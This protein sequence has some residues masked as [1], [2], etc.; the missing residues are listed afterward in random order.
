VINTIII[1][2]KRLGIYLTI[3]IAILFK[4]VRIYPN[5]TVAKSLVSGNK[6]NITGTVIKSKI[7]VIEYLKILRTT[8]IKLISCLAV[9]SFMCLKILQI[10]HINIICPRIIARAIPVL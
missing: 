8:W 5:K 6:L 9:R 1:I 10:I 7:T 3:P 2:V 4:G